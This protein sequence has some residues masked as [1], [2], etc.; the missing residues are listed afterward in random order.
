MS[1]SSIEVVDEW[2]KNFTDPDVVNR[3]V[4]P[5]AAFVSL[6]FDN[7]ELKKILPWAGTGHGPGAFTGNVLEI[8]RR[9]ENQN[10][11]VAVIFESGENVAVFGRFTYRSK[12]WGRP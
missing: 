6:N 9:W 11:E 10:F 8:F 4:A 5:D 1:N 2:L 7:P 3:I 12:R